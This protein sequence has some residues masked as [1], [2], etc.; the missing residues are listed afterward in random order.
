[1]PVCSKVSAI[2]EID[3]GDLDSFDVEDQRMRLLASVPVCRQSAVSDPV[4]F[5]KFSVF[6]YGSCRSLTPFVKDVVVCGQ[7]YVESAACQISGVTVWCRE[8]R[9]SCVGLACESVL[10]ICHGQVCAF[11]PVSDMSEIGC[12]IVPV[13]ESVRIL[14]LCGMHHHVSHHTYRYGIPVVQGSCS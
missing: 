6:F 13:S 14:D 10:H 2:S 11:Y 12:E 5:F 7:E 8:C 1:M 4:A 3:N 9:I